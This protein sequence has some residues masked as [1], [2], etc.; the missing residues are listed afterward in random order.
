MTYDL[1]DLEARVI[2]CLME[3]SVLT[4]DQYPLTLNAL[5]NA[6]NQK[7]SRDPVMH[8]DQTTVQRTVRGLKEKHLVQIDENFKSQVEKYNQRLCNTLLSDFQFEPPQFA[9]VCVLLLR[10]PRTPGELR[11]NSGR[12][13]TFADNGEVVEALQSLMHREGD[14]IVAELPRKPGRR[15]S[16]YMH[17]FSGEIEDA[18]VTAPAAPVAAASSGS[19]ADR[20]ARLEA[21]DEIRELTARYCHAVVDG[22]VE[23][24]VELFAEDGAFRSGNAAP[25]GHAA[26]REFYAPLAGQ[27][28]KPFVQNHV[29]ELDGD[30]ATGRCSV[31]IRVTQDGEA[32]TQ[33][34]HY[35]D[36]YRR[37]DGRWRFAE[38]Q[39]IRYHNAPW[40]SGWQ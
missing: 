20:L 31:E 35:L 40:R 1:T 3:K 7:S 5:T 25:Q 29:I 18:V 30:E 9:I 2:G 26:L 38:R 32:Y 12:L 17:L 34:G 22:D 16:E 11:A 10:G 33:A 6:C 39:Y 19:A 8:L 13:H 27:A 24:L 36:R 28:F 4:P 23:S 14:P 15:D 37:I 21:R